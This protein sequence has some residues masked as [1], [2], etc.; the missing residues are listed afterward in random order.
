MSVVEHL[1]DTKYIGGCSAETDDC[2]T[3]SAK[4]VERVECFLRSLERCEK[5]AYRLALYED[6]Q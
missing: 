1:L 5:K 2:E 4:E 6:T 3:D